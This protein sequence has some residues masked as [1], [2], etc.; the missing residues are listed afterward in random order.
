MNIAILPTNNQWQNNNLFVLE[1]AR[2][3]VLKRYVL[4]KNQLENEGH[5]IQTI[6]QFDYN[7]IDVII[8]QQLG[9]AWPFLI[10]CIKNNPDLTVVN[11]A[12]EPTIIHSLNRKDVFENKLFDYILTWNDNLIDQIKYIET[13]SFSYLDPVDSLIDFNNKNFLC[14]INYYKKSKADNSIY[15]ERENV[16]KFFAKKDTID[17]FGYN[18]DKHN[19]ENIK[20]IY[21][22]PVEA[23]IEV[24]KNYK[25]SF[26]FENV[27]NEPGYICEKLF[28]CFSAGCVPIFYGAPN[29]TDLIPQSTFI[30]YRKF[31]NLEDLEKYL[32]SIDEN[33]YK[34][35]LTDIKNFMNSSEYIKFTSEGFVQSVSKVISDVKIKPS[36]KKSVSNIKW[37]FLIKIIKNPQ[38]FWKDKP[39]LFN[40]LTSW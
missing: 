14:M 7:E 9:T 5:S 35:Y 18:W 30:D 32:M 34:K 28:D 27:N 11:Y 12:T 3:N 33:R 24:L 8:F 19:D 13:R 39:F 20:N 21:R 1:N 25:F 29:V 23:K 6:D 36:L 38:V 2:D 4:L 17:L 26:A 15:H 10:N 16:L 31:V 37:E 22:G 40:Y